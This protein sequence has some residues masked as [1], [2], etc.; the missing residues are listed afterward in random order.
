M[1]KSIISKCGKRNELEKLKNNKEDKKIVDKKKENV[2]PDEQ[3]S[4][5]AAENIK[6]LSEERNDY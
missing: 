6:D 1:K 5:G 4:G 2:K 3:N